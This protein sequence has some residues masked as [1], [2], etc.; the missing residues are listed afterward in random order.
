MMKT[1]YES[2]LDD[3]ES[4]ADKQNEDLPKTLWDCLNGCVV[5]NLD[6]C[7]G[8]THFGI[9]HISKAIKTKYKKDFKPLT[10]RNGKKLDP[11]VLGD[12]VAIVST[13]VKI[14]WELDPQTRFHKAMEDFNKKLS[15]VLSNFPAL[16]YLYSYD[17]KN[18]DLDEFDEDE[19]V[20]PDGFEII[21]IINPQKIKNYVGAIQITYGPRESY[22][23]VKNKWVKCNSK[24]HRGGTYTVKILDNCLLVR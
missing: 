11:A 1:L 7:F 6:R 8:P 15:K 18:Y 14:N 13:Q 16:T 3:F 10:N 24:P 9:S 19:H 17:I 4:L 5:D 20:E 21:T 23:K 2:L 22:K 12:I